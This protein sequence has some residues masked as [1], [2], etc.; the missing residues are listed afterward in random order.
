MRVRCRKKRRQRRGTG[1]WRRRDTPA[2]LQHGPR[3][4]SHHH[5]ALVA[6]HTHIRPRC[7]SPR[8]S[9]AWP[10][11]RRPRGRRAPAAR[12]TRRWPSWRRT[13]SPRRCRPTST[14]ATTST[15]SPSTTDTQRPNITFSSCVSGR[16]GAQLRRRG[17]EQPRTL[18]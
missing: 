8:V 5:L 1:R 3:L 12:G 11:A 4:A 6:R 16:S 2:P 10:R 9:S 13:P 18:R 15:P 14:C 7:R 17:A